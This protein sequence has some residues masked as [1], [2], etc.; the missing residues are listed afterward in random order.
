MKKSSCA[1]PE[2]AGKV[3]FPLRCWINYVCVCAFWLWCVTWGQCGIFHL[4]QHWVANFGALRIWDTQPVLNVPQCKNRKA[5]NLYC[6]LRNPLTVF[7]FIFPELSVFMHQL[8]IA[9]PLP[10]HLP[11]PPS[12]W[13]LD[14]I[15]LLKNHY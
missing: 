1:I 6:F 2:G 13:I 11:S 3:F 8:I 4:D 10:A 5:T 12:H 14:F 15:F 9:S 7:V